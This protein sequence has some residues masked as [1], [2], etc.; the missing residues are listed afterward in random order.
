[1]LSYLTVTLPLNGPP[2][3]YQLLVIVLLK[4]DMRSRR[5][6]LDLCTILQQHA[7]IIIS[8]VL[9]SDKMIN[10]TTFLTLPAANN[11]CK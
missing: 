2:C 4:R 1:M 3:H 5:D 9:N 10:S 7:I 11:I 8:T 6:Y